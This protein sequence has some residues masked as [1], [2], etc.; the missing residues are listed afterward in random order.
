MP[1]C[2]NRFEKFARIFSRRHKQTTF[3]DA[4]FLG[5]LRVNT[6]LTF[7]QAAV[8]DCLNHYAYADATFLAERLFAEGKNWILF[9]SH[10]NQI[11]S[12]Q[13]FLGVFFSL[14]SPQK[15]KMFYKDI[16]RMDPIHFV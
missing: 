2:K 13:V 14:I 3:S 7:F 16:S 11:K 5:V 15:H 1:V 4:G 10:I 8:W 12:L 6:L 9:C